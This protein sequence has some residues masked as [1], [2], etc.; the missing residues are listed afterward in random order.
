MPSIL[1][2]PDTPKASWFRL[3]PRISR[4]HSEK[5][6]T[7]FLRR[8]R[9]SHHEISYNKIVMPLDSPIYGHPTPGHPNC[10]SESDFRAVEAER[11][12]IAA[13][14]AQIA[15]LT[16]SLSGLKDE[17][18]NV[19]SG[20]TRQLNLM[21]FDL[22]VL[23]SSTKKLQRMGSVVDELS[24]FATRCKQCIDHHAASVTRQMT[25][26]HRELQRDQ[27]LA[28]HDMNAAVK[29]FV[30]SNELQIQELER[31]SMERLDAMERKMEERIQAI[32]IERRLEDESRAQKLEQDFEQRLRPRVDS[33]A[34]PP[35]T[36]DHRSE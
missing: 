13:L 35:P 32:M 4:R 29:D 18:D 12:R 23:S 30:R 7:F 15:S 20:L 11:V 26:V 9:I 8:R 17:L 14:E 3:T 19:A 21:N 34:T 10:S 27:D 5:I 36:P 31:R 1:S 25:T 2:P 6:S 22:G 28:V 16:D 33:P 24:A